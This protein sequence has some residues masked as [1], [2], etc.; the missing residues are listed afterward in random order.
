[1]DPLVSIIVP[2]YNSEQYLNMCLESIIHQ[3]Y[4]NYVCILIDDGS[5]DNSSNICKEYCRLDS[6]FFF[7]KKKNGGVSSAR[8][9]CLQNTRGEYICFVDSDDLVDRNFLAIML[10]NIKDTGSDLCQCYFT[11]DLEKLGEGEMQ[12]IFFSSEQ[13]FQDILVFDKIS[14]VVYGKLFNKNIFA[15]I[16]FNEKCTVL[17]DVEIL[18]KI[19]QS[20]ITVSEISYNGYYYRPTPNSLISQGLNLGKLEGSIVSHNSCVEILKG[21]EKEN[22]GYRFKYSSLFNWLL[23]ISRQDDWK[24]ISLRISEESRKDFR[25]KKIK[26][27]IPTFQKTILTINSKCPTVAHLLCKLI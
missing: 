22:I 5:T 7:I 13:I 1:M 12:D 11:R 16:E 26:K 23:R 14:P 6:R 17:E 18:T 2:V 27:V 8:N 20:N 24:E 21:T 3:S 9:L 4:S 19:M 25:S 10:R 15:D